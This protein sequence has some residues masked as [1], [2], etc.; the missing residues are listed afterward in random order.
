MPLLQTFGND[1]VRGYERFGPT[2]SLA[3][4]ELISTTVVGAG[5][6]ATISFPSLGT[7]AA[8]YKHLQIRYTARST[9]AANADNIAIRFNSDSGSNY[10]YHYVLGADTSTVTSGGAG[11]QSFTY[12]PSQIPGSNATVGSFGAGVVDLLDFASANKAKTIKALSGYT[13]AGY[14]R[15]ALSSGAWFS[16]AAVTQ[17]DLSNSG[18]FVQYSR[19]SL[20][21]LRG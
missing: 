12:V 6:V 7:S 3:A 5:G 11:S 2:G 9:V 20:Y 14:Q 4:Y 18:N 15:V 17:I 13:M 19:F 10:S 8:N 1:T 16:N 21:G